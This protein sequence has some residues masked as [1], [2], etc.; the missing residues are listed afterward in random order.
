T[1]GARVA[2]ASNHVR[3]AGRHLLNLN[4]K[5]PRREYVGEHVR[6]ASFPRGAGDERGITRV[7]THQLA[8]ERDGVATRYSHRLPLSGDRSGGVVSTPRSAIE[9]GSSGPSAETAAATSSSRSRRATTSTQPP[10]DAPSAFAP[11]APA[12][13]A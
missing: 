1:A 7:H 3:P 11:S 9:N 5:A 10:P 8:C 13:R 4:A 2:D 6:G 12:L